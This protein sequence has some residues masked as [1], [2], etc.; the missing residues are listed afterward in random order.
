[1]QIFYFY[2]LVL[3]YIGDLDPDVHPRLVPKLKFIPDE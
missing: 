3:C 1:M 2:V